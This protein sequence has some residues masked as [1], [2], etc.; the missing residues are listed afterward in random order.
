MSTGNGNGNGND[1][2]DAMHTLAVLV[3]RALNTLNPN[4]ALAQTVYKLAQSHPTLESFHKA[5]AVFGR[6]SLQ[7]V[8]F[9]LPPLFSTLEGVPRELTIP[10]V[11]AQE[12]YDFCQSQDILERAF[13]QPGAAA[14]SSR[15][16]I[17]IVDRDV[18]EPDA[19]VRAGLTTTTTTDTGKHVFKAPQKSALGLDRLAAEKR[20]EKEA[21][22]RSGAVKRLKY[23][24]DDDDEDSQSD[25]KSQSPLAFAPFAFSLALPDLCF[26]YS[27]L[28]EECPFQLAQPTGRDPFP[29]GRSLRHGPPP[30][31]RTPRS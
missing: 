13:S 23:D 24:D 15:G 11:Q 14:A 16:G 21:L 4:P 19:P 31:R 20:R 25:F 30:P 6:F 2:M 7:Q 8:Q 10:R 28:A 5:I 29:P 17:H 18:L 9:P 22:E 27:A 1:A 12:I 3:S 26:A